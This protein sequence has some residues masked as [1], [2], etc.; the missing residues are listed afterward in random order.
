MVDKL[1]CYFFLSFYGENIQSKEKLIK[2]PKE[3]K[4]KKEEKKKRS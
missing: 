4:S 3:T 1:T 2:I